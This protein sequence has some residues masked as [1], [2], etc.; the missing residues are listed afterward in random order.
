MDSDRT[1][2]RIIPLCRRS[3][4]LSFLSSESL[5]SA[6]RKGGRGEA[7]SLPSSSQEIFSQ[8]KNGLFLKSASIRIF[9]AFDARPPS[10]STMDNRISKHAG[11]ERMHSFA[12]RGLSSAVVPFDRVH[13]I[14]VEPSRTE[15]L[16]NPLGCCPL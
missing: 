11:V 2:E 3:S 8:E 16:I 7:E 12:G 15:R 4:R 10:L 6:G 13:G 1:V 5:I 9:R 14:A